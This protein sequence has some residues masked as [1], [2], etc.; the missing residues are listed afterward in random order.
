[1]IQRSKLLDLCKFTPLVFLHFMINSCA[2][3]ED[4]KTITISADSPALQQELKVE[5]Q[6]KSLDAYLETKPE[7]KIYLQDI[8][9]II[10]ASIATEKKE[11]KKA[12]QLWLDAL[13]ISRGHLGEYSFKQWLS[14]L[15]FLHNQA[16][17]HKL[18][19]L[20]AIR[21]KH[22]SL[23]KF[24]RS[25]GIRKNSQLAKLV[26]RTL[27]L[28]PIPKA[29]NINLFPLSHNPKKDPLLEQA[30]EL[31]CKAPLQLHKREA[32]FQK[33]LKPHLRPYWQGLKFSCLKKPLQAIRSLETAAMNFSSTKNTSHLA[34]AAY[35]QLAKLQRWNDQR[36]QAAKTYQSLIK[37][38]QLQKRDGRFF[39]S[40][41]TEVNLRY[42]ND[43]L[44]ASRYQALE[45]RYQIARNYTNKALNEIKSVHSKL[46]K[47]NSSTVQKLSEFEA[48]AYHILA[49]RI[50]LEHKNYKESYRLTK[51]T[52][53]IPHLSKK[54][55]I[56]T[57]WY[58]GLY[59]YLAGEF[60][61]AIKSWKP[62]ATNK[63]HKQFKEKSLF[64]LARVYA[65]KGDHSKAKHYFKKLE[66]LDP[67]SFYATTA[68]KLAN[69]DL[70]DNW[71]RMF[72]NP[73]ILKQ[74]FSNAQR[75]SIKGL[76]NRKKTRRML[77]KTEILVSLKFGNLS[78]LAALDLLKQAR[79]TINIRREKESFIYLSRLLYASHNYHRGIKITAELK[80]NFPKL[81]QEWPGQILVYYPTPYHRPFAQASQISQLPL[82]HLYSIARQESIF[83]PRA[84]SHADAMGLMQLIETTAYKM[85]KKAKLNLLDA[86]TEL[87]DPKINLQLSGQYLKDLNLEFNS[88][89]PAIYAA[90]NA[91]SYPVKIWLK[92]RAHPDL[93]TWIECIAF[94]ETRN[95]VQKVWRNAQIYEYLDQ[96]RQNVAKFKINDLK[97]TKHEVDI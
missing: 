6:L 72:P 8:R 70:D 56:Q 68:A 88:N 71:K 18:Q 19:K 32:S 64:W 78:Q 73:L 20:V 94:S 82:K 34:I 93:L 11:Y 89:H 79:K 92:R 15:K 96:G 40:S 48:E 59:H 77:I 67:F 76:T 7:D 85:A 21:K 39:S 43:L 16:H 17:A 87:L 29:A 57:L 69:I 46:A 60:S 41:T 58:Q 50:E 61:N 37:T 4:I 28:K 90:Y 81:W 47:W 1:M 51:K 33:S 25:Q 24:L 84:K 55:R 42:I 54:W 75:F 38:W 66:K 26:D 14:N 62:V 49:F 22:P 63:F 2:H 5:K 91:G 27:G 97:K 83:N 45:G 52:L 10:L 35:E 95:Y 9:K 80:S 12:D 36:A 3:H 23:N 86:K 53:A 31:Y 30:Q 74:S 13:M 65:Q 44:W